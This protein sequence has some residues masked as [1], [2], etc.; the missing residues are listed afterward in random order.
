[1]RDLG[2]F[3]SKRLQAGEGLVRVRVKG[4]G[5]HPWTPLKLPEGVSLEIRVSPGMDG[6][7]PSWRSLGGVQ[8]NAMIEA[9][10]GSLVLDGL[11]LA[12]DGVPSV[13]NLVRVERGHLVLNRC[14][15]SAPGHLGDGEGTLVSF[16]APGT[17]PLS[18]ISGSSWPF[19]S[20]ADKPTLRMIDTALTTGG[21]ALV[22]N[23]GRGLM[24][25]SN[26]VVAAGR[27][28]F[29]LNPGRVAR[30]RLETD[31]IL[32]HCTI[33]SERSVLTLGPWLGTDPGPNRPWLVSTQNSAVFGGYDRP[34]QETALLRVDVEAMARGA[35]FVQSSSDVFEVHQFV[36]GVGH[37]P[38]R[39]G[40][41][42]LRQQW[43]GLW[44]DLH[45]RRVSG[46]SYPGGGSGVR[47]VSILRP[48]DV[49]PGDL[50]IDPST[51][52]GR[53]PTALGADLGRLGIAPTPRG[54][55]G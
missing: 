28:A 10:G 8:A 42:D 1:G 49:Q 31:L 11:I 46:P 6:F 37:A 12:T 21:D 54:S 27:S 24:A 22:G 39:S 13:K 45:T 32:D 51:L 44:G 38:P 53:A 33:A 19:D 16:D 34:S 9:V 47:P 5:E 41:T 30:D 7:V 2:L 3:L 52:R 18:A 35:I 26:C 4:R 55:R 23:L 50:A 25:L 48:G 40:R 43:V 36:A 17:Q 15:F 20:H 14:Q 29:V